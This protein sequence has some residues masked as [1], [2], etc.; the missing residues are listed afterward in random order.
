MKLNMG[1]GNNKLEKFINVD[2]SEFCNPDMVLDLELLPWPWADNSVDEVVFNHCLEH[3]G[4][5]TAVF[6]GM[7]KELYRVCQ[8]DALVRI[9][10]PH[11]RHDHFL[12]DPTHVRPIS[13][14]LLGLF[15]KALN[16]DWKAKGASNTPLAHQLGVDFEIILPYS[17]DFD[18]PYKTM[19]QK[20]LLSKK[21]WELALR[22]RN[23]VATEYRIELRVR[24]DPSLALAS[25]PLTAFLFEPDWSGAVWK[26]VLSCYLKAFSP[27]EPVSLVIPLDGT[28]L[29]KDVET[30]VLTVVVGSGRDAFPDVVLI[31]QKDNLLETLRH[32]RSLQWLI[33]G[34]NQVSSPLTGPLGERFARAL[35]KFR[36]D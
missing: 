13:P 33:H 18:E 2:H 21:D 32:Y 28:V 8:N 29:L 11:P 4:R 5:E 22:E 15:S 3:L 17:I 14:Q 30:W 31:D 20:G 7:F 26:Q 36:S 34:E 6:L 1:C 16:D 9:T 35:A 12:N 25:T 10:V 27:G 24:K 23:N 19:I